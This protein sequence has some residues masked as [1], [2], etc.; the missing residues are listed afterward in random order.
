MSSQPDYYAILEVSENASPEVITS[1][2]RSLARKYHPDTNPSPAA[3]TRMK[4]INVAYDVLSDR[5]K[6]AAYD[7]QRAGALKPA[8]AP[9]PKPAQPA[10]AP[11][12]TQQ[13]AAKPQ[14]SAAPRT[15]PPPPPKPQAAQPPPKPAPGPSPAPVPA[16]GIAGFLSS[17]AFTT[18][19][20]AFIIIFAV[21]TIIAEALVQRDLEWLII[22][23]SVLAAGVVVIVRRNPKAGSR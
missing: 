16:G 22:P 17:P 9:P 12:V 21:L 20:I 14:P 3:N 7:R 2:Y 5:N 18:F 13:P 11:H 23:F 4:S 19:V 8:A 1:A 15:T 10:K 6:R